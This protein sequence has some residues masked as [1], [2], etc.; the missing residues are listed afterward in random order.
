MHG[1]ARGRDE[2]GGAVKEAFGRLTGVAVVHVGLRR[3]WLEF[4][5]DSLERHRSGPM[6][7]GEGCTDQGLRYSVKVRHTV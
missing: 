7:S 5:F 6:R 1:T 4:G 3:L 2:G